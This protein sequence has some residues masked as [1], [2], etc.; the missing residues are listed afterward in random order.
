VTWLFTL[1]AVAVVALAVGLVTGRLSGGLDPVPSS[2]PFRGLPA[3]GVGP[4]DLD[5]LRFTTVLRGYRM[6][7]VDRVLDQVAVELRRRDEEVD[8]LRSVLRGEGTTGDGEAGPVSFEAPT[9]TGTAAG[10]AGG[11]GTAAAPPSSTPAPP[12][13][14]PGTPEPGEPEPE[15][16]P[17]PQHGR[18]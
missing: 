11:S 16:E 7:E 4:A 14:A 18:F 6:D 3:E 10:T 2:S 1:L 5:V 9:G 15:P 12:S 13:T 17:L 8:R